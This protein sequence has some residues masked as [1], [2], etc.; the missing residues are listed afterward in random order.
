MPPCPGHPC[1]YTYGCL[2]SLQA[3]AA[4]TLVRGAQADTHDEAG[5][6]PP[7]SALSS[8]PTASPMSLASFRRLLRGM[9]CWRTQGSQNSLDRKWERPWQSPCHHKHSWDRTPSSHTL[10]PAA[11]ATTP[12]ARCPGIQVAVP[13]DPEVVW[14][15]KFSLKSDSIEKKR[16]Q[17]S[18]TMPFPAPGP[19]PILLLFLSRIQQVFKLSVTRRGR[20]LPVS[21]NGATVL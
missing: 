14:S 12:S 9:F 3:W 10:T 15:W 7:P 11:A 17:S 13:S 5:A 6:T 19:T 4:R 2:S 16:N 20:I 1:I 18:R 21:D 8:P